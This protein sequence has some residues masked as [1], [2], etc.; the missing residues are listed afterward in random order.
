MVDCSDFVGTAVGSSP[1]VRRDHLPGQ[2]VQQAR[3]LRRGPQ[4]HRQP[5]PRCGIGRGGTRDAPQG[6]EHPGGVA[7]TAVRAGLADRA[8][9]AD[10]PP[11]VQ[12]TRLAETYPEGERRARCADPLETRLPR[13]GRGLR[14]EH[15]ATDDAFTR[16]AVKVRCRPR[17][18]RHGGGTKT[19][20]G[21]SDG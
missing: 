1:D 14:M 12:F 7:G 3:R 11:Q 13:A 15:R 5:G 8:F 20:V 2:A 6:H 17:I 18:T 10:H 9:H 21:S 4:V 19:A 16:G